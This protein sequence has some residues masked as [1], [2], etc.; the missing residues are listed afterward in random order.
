MY[1]NYKAEL[2]QNGKMASSKLKLVVF[3]GSVRENRMCT[4]VA[5]F[6]KKQLTP[7][8]DL[9]VLDPLEL[10]L[11][12]LEKPLHFHQDQAQA[13]KVLRETEATVRSADGYLMLCAEY[14][15]T[16][17]PA[18]SNLLDHFGPS[19]YAYKPSGIICYSVGIYGGMRAAMNL[20]CLLA[21]L[22]T[23]SVPSIFAIP[24]VQNALSEDGE[25]QNDKMV[26]GLTRLMT[27]LD[28]YA[29]AMKNHRDNFGL[30]Q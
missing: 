23:P 19:T 26:P 16:V 10:Q 28:W 20:R 3:L 9:T 30:P 7:K 2:Q 25:P 17:P 11:P 6:V 8:Y 18:L 15:T 13:P 27:Q 12:L 1:R 14:N 29:Q 24:Q 4:R 22:S 21:E 5:N